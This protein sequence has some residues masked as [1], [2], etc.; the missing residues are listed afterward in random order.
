M[1]E[2]VPSS[3]ADNPLIYVK[4]LID[5]G[6]DLEEKDLEGLSVLNRIVRLGDSACVELLINAGADINSRTAD[7]STVLHEAAFAGQDHLIPRLVLHGAAVNALADEDI[8]PLH[9]AVYHGALG[10]VV[11]L[12]KAGA[13]PLA[14]D[15]RGRRPIDLADHYAPLDPKAAAILK[16]HMLMAP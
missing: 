4:A 6:L 10:G 13:N 7:S 16:H 12:L 15:L 3:I 11:A 1:G 2:N 14:V 9:D 8:T 5:S